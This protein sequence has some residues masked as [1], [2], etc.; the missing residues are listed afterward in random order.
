[1]SDCQSGAT[2]EQHM[3]AE[4]ESITEPD[5][6]LIALC[7]RLEGL[8]QDYFAAHLEWAPGLDDAASARMWALDDEKNPI[9]EKIMSLPV[10]SIAGLRA[11]VLV[12]LWETLPIWS[13]VGRLQFNPDD[14]GA[15]EALF[16]AA[17]ELTGLGL[18]V[19]DMEA[20][21]AAVV[22]TRRSRLRGMQE[23]G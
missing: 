19:R 13:N 21:L 9:A 20:R 6:E 4:Q 15:S 8:L 23:I 1:V 18:M 11:K 16:R 12:M 17:A 2:W 7:S 14:G 3:N 5:A 22:A 10:A